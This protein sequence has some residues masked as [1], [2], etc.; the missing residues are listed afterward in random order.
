[1]SD[2][3][4]QGAAEN[5]HADVVTTLLRAGADVHA[6]NDYA[7]QWSAKEGHLDVVKILLKAGDSM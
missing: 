4:L 2:E 5:G 6:E 3:A 7:L 1:M